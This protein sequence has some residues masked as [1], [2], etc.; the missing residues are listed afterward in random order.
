MTTVAIDE[1]LCLAKFSI[2]N[3]GLGRSSNKKKSKKQQAKVQ[4]SS[5]DT[6]TWLLGSSGTSEQST[7]NIDDNNDDTLL[8]SSNSVDERSVPLAI[9]GEGIQF[10]QADEHQRCVKSWSTGPAVHFSTSPVTLTTTN[11]TNYVFVG[12]QKAPDVTESNAGCTIGDGLMIK[13]PSKQVYTLPTPIIGLRAMPWTCN[14]L[15]LFQANGSVLLTNENL[16]TISQSWPSEDE[17]AQI[18][19]YTVT[20]LEQSFLPNHIIQEMNASRSL[21]VS[22]ATVTPNEPSC[23]I[24]WM[25]IDTQTDDV[26]DIGKVEL[27]TRL[28]LVNCALSNQFGTV[29]LVDMSGEWAAY[30]CTFDAAGFHVKPSVAAQLESATDFAA[31][32]TKSFALTT[33][34]VGVEYIGKDYIGVSILPR[35]NKLTSCHFIQLGK[36]THLLTVWDT[37]FG[38]KQAE[39]LLP[40]CLSPWLQLMSTATEKTTLFGVNIL[41]RGISLLHAIG[42]LSI[43]SNDITT[44]AVSSEQLLA[45]NQSAS[46]IGM[47]ERNPMAWHEWSNN[48]ETAQSTDNE[49]LSTLLQSNTS[50][51]KF[52]QAYMSRYTHRDGILRLRNEIQEMEQKI[53]EL[54]REKA[55]SVSENVNKQLRETIKQTRASLKQQ[56]HTLDLHYVDFRLSQ[57]MVATII[58][59]CFR[60]TKDGTPDMTF[61]PVTIVEDIM[62]RGLLSANYVQHSKHGYSTLLRELS[63]RN[64]NHL[65]LL[66]FKMVND[67]SENDIVAVL[68]RLCDSS[69]SSSSSSDMVIDASS[70]NDQDLTIEQYLAAAISAPSSPALLIRA[71]HRL[72][73]T[74]TLK[75]L[76]II[77]QWMRDWSQAM[78]GTIRDATAANSNS[79]SNSSGANSSASSTSLTM[80]PLPVV[81]QPLVVNNGTRPSQSVVLDAANLLLDAHLPRLVL[82]PEAQPLLKE[83][84]VLVR[85]E[86]ESLKSWELLRGMLGHY[87]LRNLL[88]EA[89]ELSTQGLNYGATSNEINGIKRMAPIP[90][91]S[92]RRQA[93]KM[94]RSARAGI[95]GLEVLQFQV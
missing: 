68:R 35:T 48:R 15:L 66:A 2:V 7:T 28:P 31:T 17:Q 57:P 4:T 95:Y 12:I 73:T 62:Q 50:V 82:T 39:Q 55:H 88:P 45:Y 56:E 65:V 90:L 49:W 11:G 52:T 70:N 36:P 19:Q 30:K 6:P 74:H 89:K 72:S 44:G 33:R 47:P 46:V 43:S 93:Q 80:S 63:A 24:R 40:A 58:A 21:L 27:Q 51:K 67:L 26:R 37:R 25:V 38:T 86:I 23:L 85:A 18:I 53:V 16:L 59:C 5:N 69:S 79:N 77:L 81:T 64:A 87:W 54:K 91:I 34:P 78:T 13:K 8:L 61:W 71:I 92:N 20:P 94:A 83:L 22:L 42:Q 14:R 1:P 9:Q 32:P 41:C 10:Y 84:Q 76:E 60:S 3:V 29:T 75:V